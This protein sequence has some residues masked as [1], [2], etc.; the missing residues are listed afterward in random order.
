MPASKLVALLLN[1]WN[2]ADRVFDGLSDAQAL[3]RHDGGSCFAW[4]LSH[5]TVGMDFFINATLRGGR[6]HPVLASQ[7]ERFG[8]SGEADDWPGIVSAVKDVRREIRYYLEGLSDEDLERTR[9]PAVRE[10]PETPLRYILYRQI[11]HHYYHIGEVAAKRSRSGY[12]AGD[13][14][15]PLADAM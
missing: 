9:V 2:D 12:D 5:L 1:T 11:T 3:E 7:Y 14:P 15:G 8:F 6:V 13:Y 10:W 4:T